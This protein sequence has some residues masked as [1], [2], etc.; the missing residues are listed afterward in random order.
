MLWDLTQLKWGINWIKPWLWSW[1]VTVEDVD[2][3][4]MEEEQRKVENDKLEVV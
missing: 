3:S 4:E 2:W 1:A